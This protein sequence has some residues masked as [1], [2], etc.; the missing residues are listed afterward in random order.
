MIFSF[1]RFLFRKGQKHHMNSLTR[2]R[3]CTEIKPFTSVSQVPGPYLAQEPPRSKSNRKRKATY[4]EQNTGVSIRPSSTSA[5]YTSL[6]SFSSNQY[7]TIS[8]SRRVPVVPSS[9]TSGVSGNAKSFPVF[10]KPKKT[11]LDKIKNIQTLVS[12]L[13][14]TKELIDNHNNNNNNSNVVNIYGINKQSQQQQQQQKSINKATKSTQTLNKEPNVLLQQDSTQMKTNSKASSKSVDEEA[15][16]ALKSEK[17]DCEKQIKRLKRDVEIL[18]DTNNGLKEDLESIIEEN[19]Q[20]TEMVKKLK[21]ENSQLGA[22]AT[23]LDANLDELKKEKIADKMLKRELRNKIIDLK[24]NIRV[25]VRVRPFLPDETGTC[26]HTEFSGGMETQNFLIPGEA[27]DFRSII[28][29]ESSLRSLSTGPPQRRQEEGTSFDFDRVF[30]AFST[31]S[32]IFEEVGEFVQSALNGYKVCVLA[33][34][35]TGSGKTYTMHGETGNKKGIV[36]RSIENIFMTIK[37]MG[38]EGWLYHLT[39]AFYEIY[40]DRIYDLLADPDSEQKTLRVVDAGENVRIDGLT[41]YKI[42][43]S[44]EVLPIYM[45]AISRRQTA[46][47]G[48]NEKSS[49]SHCIFELNIDSTTKNGGVTRHGQLN[50]VDLAGSE[51]LERSGVT[52]EREKESISINTSLSTLGRV[53][54]GLSKR[55]SHL[56]YRDSLLTRVLRPALS[57]GSKTLLLVTISP[58]QNDLK[59]S[60]STL[61]FASTAKSCTIGKPQRCTSRKK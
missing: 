13:N 28:V 17:E 44:A 58:S 50:L 60:M 15:F 32:E 6:D 59:E 18:E 46:S 12:K 24:G 2:T 31:Q 61:R 45:D 27:D 52:G 25:H 21:A 30:S 55:E 42:S 8:S 19:R 36:P 37:E 1:L 47:T 41:Y 39:V 14:N 53:I 38:S 10:T 57:K 49:R 20:L 33:Y 7:S 43:S 56:P 34:G 3:S 9:A 11:V 23:K 40:L 29:R 26:R 22:L 54:A 5:G 4:S 35:Q 51:K 16:K 48:M